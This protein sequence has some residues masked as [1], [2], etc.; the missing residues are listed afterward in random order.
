MLLFCFF[1]S[2]KVLIINF[3]E[4]TSLKL[5]NI[6]YPYHLVLIG[7]LFGI[8]KFLFLTLLIES[9]CLGSS[10]LF[11]ASTITLLR[12][13]SCDCVTS[14][15][16]DSKNGRDVDLTCKCHLSKIMPD[17]MNACGRRFPWNE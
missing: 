15:N 10:K 9:F 5:S 8:S 17:S 3:L 7:K 13:V 14:F 4:L 6:V 16:F 1:V 11:L 2:P 12:S